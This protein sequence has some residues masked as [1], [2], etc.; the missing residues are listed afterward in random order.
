MTQQQMEAAQ[1]MLPMPG[2]DPDFAQRQMMSLQTT[3]DPLR[4]GIPRMEGSELIPTWLEQRNGHPQQTQPQTQ[5]SVGQS[6]GNAVVPGRVPDGATP[7]KN[8][9]GSI[10]GYKQNGQ[11]VLFPRQ[12]AQQSSPPAKQNPFRTTPQPTVKMISPNGQQSDVPADQVAHYQSA[13]AKVV[14]KVGDTITQ[15]GQSF[16]VTA[17]DKQGQVTAAQ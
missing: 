12:S 11:Q 4:K 14:H 9:F 10:I 6:Q 15:N 16:K 8:I 5:Q 3:L 13:G 7:V 17:V 1:Q 2:S